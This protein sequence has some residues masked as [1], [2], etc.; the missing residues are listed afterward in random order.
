MT[1]C[2]NSVL[3]NQVLLVPLIADGT[4]PFELGERLFEAAAEP[5][6]FYRVRRAG[7]ND[8]CRHGGFFYLRRL[9]RFRD[10]CL[11]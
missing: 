6:E 5:K 4:V 2:K 3:Q 10:R 1:L 9:A 8:V 7:H 11:R